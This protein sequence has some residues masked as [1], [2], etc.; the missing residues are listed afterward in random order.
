[1]LR[2]S[3][4]KAALKLPMRKEETWPSCVTKEQS[5]LRKLPNVIE[6]RKKGQSFILDQENGKL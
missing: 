3:G 6:M 4:L 1:V 5:L 2:E